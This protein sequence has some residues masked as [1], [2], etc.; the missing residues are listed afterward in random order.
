VTVHL[1]GP[2]A[3]VHDMSA[4]REGGPDQLD[5]GVLDGEDVRLQRR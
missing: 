5:G 4:A 1:D 3:H 2:I